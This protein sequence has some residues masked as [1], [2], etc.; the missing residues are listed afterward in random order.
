MAENQNY[1]SDLLEGTYQLALRYYQEEDWP[2]AAKWLNTI[3]EKVSEYKDAGS[4]LAEA[5]KQVELATLYEL[6][7]QALDAKNWETARARFQKVLNID[8]GYEKAK[9]L[10]NKA[11]EEIELP[12]LYNQAIEQWHNLDWDGAIE[13]L[14]V[15][16]DLDP[17][18][19]DTSLLKQARQKKVLEEDYKWAL[20]QYE[21]AERTGQESDWREAATLLQNIPPGYKTVSPKLAHAQRRLKFF[22]LSRKGKEHHAREE[23][24]EA[25]AYLKQATDLDSRDPDLAAKLAEAQEKL[26]EQE[27]ARHQKMLD[28]YKRGNE[29]Y[30]R[31]KW[32]EAVAY[33]EDASDIEPN[34]A[35]LRTKLGEARKKLRRQRV[36]RVALG[37]LNVVVLTVVVAVFQ[38]QIAKIGDDIE[39]W[40]REIRATPTPT[41]AIPGIDRIEVWM[42]GGQLDLDR[43][44]SL[45]GGEAVVL[46]VIVFDTK[47]KRYTSDDLVCKWSVA[48]LGDEDVEINTDLCKTFYTPSQEYSSQTIIFEVEGRE[49][50][51][52][53]VDPVS[54]KFDIVK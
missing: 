23:W 45:A 34:Y 21:K 15:I 54:M 16:R 10:Y 50:Q 20:K 9:E 27:A 44:P 52:R 3:V 29:Q 30:Q 6:G 41:V 7:Q 13:T 33:L 8:P 42:D 47:G 26:R 32:K 5:Q 48:P 39:K 17:H 31:G 25:V 24:E 35:D 14:T 49:Q 12:K 18:Y 22:E 4:L 1:D 37:I 40:W 46:E 43:L 51:F 11:H 2:N 38:N 36:I 53:P 19:M 28:L